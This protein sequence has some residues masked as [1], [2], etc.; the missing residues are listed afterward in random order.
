MDFSS[1]KVEGI[2]NSKQPTKQNKKKKVSFPIRS[3]EEELK[4]DLKLDNRN[5]D[6]SMYNKVYQFC[7]KCKTE[8]VQYIKE[9]NCNCI[10][11]NTRIQFMIYTKSNNPSEL[12]N[13]LLMI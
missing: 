9:G 10:Y 6:I 5:L 7:E 8:T 3:I 2:V 12:Q 4:P 1:F 11:C 13:T